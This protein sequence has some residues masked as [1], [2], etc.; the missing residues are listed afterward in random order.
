MN[1]ILN[2]IP[3]KHLIRISILLRPLLKVYFKG[4]KFTDPIDNSKYRIFLPYGYGENIR[5]N[6]LCP[7]T[8]SLERHRLLWL[9]LE[10]NTTFFNDKLKILHIAPEQPFYKKFK[11]IKN[12]DYI[13]CD[14]NSPLADIKADICNL[15]FKKFEFDLII[16]NHVLEHINDDLKAIREI[17]RVLKKNGVAILQV[18]IDE[19]LSKTFEDKTII[20]PKKKSEL[21][22]QYDHVR[23]Y[24]K[25][26][27]D[28]LK[29]VGFKVKK[30]DI[31]KK[32]SEE[33]IKKYCLPKYEKIP[34]VIKN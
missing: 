9:F 31:Q 7:G 18:P 21:F 22:G 34:F 28:R 8:L 12:W 5:K 30:I 13:T 27:Y 10:R 17:Y 16:C 25:D 24:G 2:L 19:S 11:S 4:S 33:E 29:S 14:L 23:K 26:Y 3:R 32:L 6:A 20:D 1:F 15:P